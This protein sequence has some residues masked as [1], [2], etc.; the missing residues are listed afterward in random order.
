MLF[1]E[2]VFL[3]IFFPSF[4]L[5]YLLCGR[6]EG[7]RCGVILGASVLFYTWSEPL[8]VPV[9]LASAVADH[10]IV[11]RIERLPRPSRQAKLLLAMGV[12]IN[13]GILIHYKY[14]RFL[15]QN[16]RSR[17]R[18]GSGALYHFANRRFLHRL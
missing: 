16:L 8:F 12:L 4:Y 15:L 2:P 7:L 14:T 11:L 6:R 13:L 5:L 9:V 18:T 10:L 1:Y 17:S 3:F